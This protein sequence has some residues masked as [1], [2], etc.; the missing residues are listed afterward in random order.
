MIYLLLAKTIVFVSYLFQIHNLLDKYVKFPTLIDAGVWLIFAILYSLILILAFY[1]YLNL[2][3]YPTSSSWESYQK[4]GF[5]AFLPKLR[6]NRS[7]M[8]IYD[9]DDL[10]LNYFTYCMVPNL[11]IIVLTLTLLKGC[12][13]TKT[14]D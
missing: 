5:W 8:W 11:A 7:W 14:D 12:F 10:H 1:L 2:N 6:L 9:L 4:L 3:T 13:F